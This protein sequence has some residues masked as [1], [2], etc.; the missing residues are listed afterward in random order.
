MLVR[1]TRLANDS[2]LHGF[3]RDG[4]F[5]DCYTVQTDCADRPI[6]E[7]AQR[8]FVKLPGWI[9]A[10]LAIRD[11]GVAGF[12]LKT[13]TYLPKDLDFRDAIKVGDYINFFCV[14]SISPNEIILGEDD[15]H[16][17][18]RISVYRDRAA[19][20]RISLATWVRTHNRLG[21]I[22]LG[23]ITPFHVL[24]VNSQLRALGRHL[25]Q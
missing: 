24:I 17:D 22:Y 21:K 9:N 3:F 6:A 16:L 23:T 8:L 1:K 4:D 19:S 10:L 13:T 5:L 11:L 20:G 18:F 25:A 12:G 15:L 2:R 14:H 7:V